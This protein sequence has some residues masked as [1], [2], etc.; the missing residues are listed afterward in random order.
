MK[1][2]SPFLLALGATIASFAH[3]SFGVELV[4]NGKAVATIVI[5][6]QALPIEAYAAKELQYHVEAST[7]A[8]LPI[9]SGPAKDNSPSHVY[10]GNCTRAGTAGVDPSGLPGNGYIVKTLGSD[11]YIA[12]KDSPGDPL[13]NDTRAGTLFGLYDLLESNMHVAWLWPG[14]LGEVIPKAKDLSLTPADATVQPRYWF[15]EWRAGR[16][17]GERVWLRRQRF[18]RTQRPG[19]GHAFGKYWERFNQT[20]P[21]FFAMLP[22]GT[23]RLEPHSDGPEWNHMCVSEPG[24]WQQIIDDWKA[25]GSPEFLNVCENDGWAGCA[26]ARCLSWDEPDPENPVPFDKRLDAAREQFEHGRSWQLQMGSLSDRYARFWKTVTDEAVKIRPDVTVISYAYDNYRKPPVKAMLSANVLLGFVPDAVFPYSKIESELFQKEWLGWEKTGAKMFLRPNYTSQEPN[27]PAFYAR[28]MAADLK[29]AVSHGVRGFD[30]DSL[31]SQ[32]SVQGPT[33]YTLP[34]ILNHP[35]ASVDD[36]LDEF[37]SAF[38]AAKPAIKEYFELWE[39]IYPQYMFEDYQKKLRATKGKY[40]A[41]TYGPFYTLAPDIY[42]TEAMTRG[43]AL[44]EKARN[45][46]TGDDLALARIEWLGKGFHHC[47]LILATERANEHDVDTGD[48]SQLQPAYQALVDF[49]TQNAEYDK[50]NFAGITA[51]NERPWKGLK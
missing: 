24:F 13:N 31:D 18:G 48:K 27:F 6:E 43:A 21:E 34:K 29:F 28:P 33:L 16:A 25:K 47:E 11:L 22:D 15:K 36:V 2:P 1:L 12:G 50:A 19:Y 30:F 10:L 7:G 32:Y 9:V 46:A 41:G 26:C 42:T 44:L 17:E 23:R 40:G 39:S 45:L 3:A 5:P 49:R 20:H 8:T 51:H 38:G 4:R 14:K 37:Y 35:D